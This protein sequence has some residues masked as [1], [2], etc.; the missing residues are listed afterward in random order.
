MLDSAAE[1][2]AATARIAHGQLAWFSIGFVPSALYGPLPEVIRR[3]RE[4]QPTVE[5]SLSELTTVQQIEALKAGRIDVGFGRL[6]FADKRIS[7]EVISKEAVV[8][9]LPSS[10]R[11]ARH[12]RIALAKL[13]KE[14]LLL[15]PAK[16]RPSYADQVL[17]MFHARG[18]RPTIALEANEMQTAIGLVVAGVGYAL[19][20]E[21]VQGLHRVGVVYLPLADAGVSTPVIL[22]CRAGDDSPLLAQFR[23]MVADERR[24]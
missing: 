4:A 11:L 7:G 13:V 1:L 23:A 12:K 3:F 9:A 10:H 5:V 15:Y 8:A 22:N 20:P 21:S 19:V 18:L 16:P 24:S 14:P 6:S 17:Q 2:R